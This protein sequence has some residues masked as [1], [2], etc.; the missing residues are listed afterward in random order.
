VL[1]AAGAMVFRALLLRCVYEKHEKPGFNP[2]KCESEILVNGYKVALVQ[3]KAKPE[4]AK[5]GFATV[6]DCAP[7]PNIYQVVQ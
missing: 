3:H 2:E 5:D 1:T 4:V 6:P 7:S